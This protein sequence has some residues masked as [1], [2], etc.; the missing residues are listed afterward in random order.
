MD[1]FKRLLRGLSAFLSIL[2]NTAAVLSTVATL[3]TFLG[4]GSVVFGY[5]SGILPLVFIGVGVLILSVI[6]FIFIYTLAVEVKKGVTNSPT[7]T[8]YPPPQTKGEVELLLKEVVYQY[9]PDGQ[10]MRQRKRFKIRVLRDGVDRFM[11]RYRWTGSGKC[12]IKSLT[13]GFNIAN[14]RKEEFWDY[15]DVT[16]PHPLRKNEE[17]DFT[18]EWELFDVV[19]SAVPFLSTMIDYETKHLSMRVILPPNLAPKGAY[20]YEFANYIDTL[21]VST[22]PTQWNAATQS[23]SYDGP[24]PKKY[25]K[26]LIRWYS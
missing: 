2:I 19:T 9:F 21:P 26:F 18:I 1:L 3:I 11:D 4:L 23:I 6:L 17:A 15:F 20:C 10:T 12:N 14:E 8:I 13:S 5:I 22:Q 7:A 16:F 25:H 24:R